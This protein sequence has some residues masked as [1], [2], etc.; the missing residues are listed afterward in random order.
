MLVQISAS[1]LDDARFYSY[2]YADAVIHTAGGFR[3]LP[4]SAGVVKWI[5]RPHGP[6]LLDKNQNLWCNEDEEG[7][8]ISGQPGRFMFLP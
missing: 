6:F 3:S 1:S 8:A 5:G 4:F 7:A 2:D